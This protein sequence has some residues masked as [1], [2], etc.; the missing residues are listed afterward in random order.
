MKK[1]SKDSL[2]I[3]MY[4]HKRIPSREGGIEVVVG[5]LAPRMVQLGHNVTCYNRLGHHVS[6]KEHDLER[7]KNYK[8]VRLKNV[9]TINR[10]GIAAVTSSFFGAICTAF[11]KYDIFM[12]RD[13]QLFA[14]YQRFLERKL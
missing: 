8:G 11:G 2:N 6:G 1:Q 3:A 5:E 9:F 10:K 4:G 14:G 7:L 13:R 12:Q